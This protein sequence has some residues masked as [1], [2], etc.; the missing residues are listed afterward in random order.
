M[1]DERAPTIAPTGQ[2]ER[3]SACNRLL[4]SRLEDLA[5]ASMADYT[6][7]IIDYEP[8]SIQMLRAPLERAGYRVEV[9][10]DGQSGIQKFNALKPSAVIIEAMLPK[11]HGFEVCRELKND[12]SRERK[13]HSRLCVGPTFGWQQPG[14]AC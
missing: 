7:L 14:V 2:A 1:F 6:I 4:L 8:R 5:R 13:N 11:R 10:T 12:K 3:T 9:A